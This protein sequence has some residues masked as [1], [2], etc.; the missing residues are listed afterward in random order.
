MK[1]HYDKSVDALSVTFK[2]GKVARTVEV[3][4]EIMV[5]FDASGSP[6][7]IEILDASTKVGKKQMSHINIGGVQVPLSA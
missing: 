5:D 6:L 1:I 4:P 3:A 2:R 7:Y